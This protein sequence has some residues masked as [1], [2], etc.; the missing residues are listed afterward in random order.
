VSGCGPTKNGISLGPRS[1][2]AEKQSSGDD[3]N[4]KDAG[5]EGGDGESLGESGVVAGAEHAG[6]TA[7][8]DGKLMKEGENRVLRWV[9]EMLKKEVRS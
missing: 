4:Q 6:D 3:K 5:G 7:D 2:R 9:I 1:A 8:G